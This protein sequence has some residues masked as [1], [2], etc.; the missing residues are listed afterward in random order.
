MWIH[1]LL[2]S[3]QSGRS[4][5]RRQPA[6]SGRK[7]RRSTAT[8]LALEQLED[9]CLPSSYTA[10]NAAQLAADITAANAAGG[11][12]TITLTAP[13]SSPYGLTAGLSIAANDDLT[14]VGNNDTIE[15]PVP[16]G[17]HGIGIAVGASLTLENL[18]LQNF[19][20]RELGQGVAIYNQ[21]VLTLSAVTVRSN[22]VL[23]S[24]TSGVARGGAIWSNGSLTLENGTLF[25]DNEAYGSSNEY[26]PGSNAY[27]GALYIA[28]GTA[29]IN[30]TSF[31]GNVALGGDGSGLPDGT[32]FGGAIYVA[33]GQVVMS[34]TT[35]NGNSVNSIG[36]NRADVCYGG[37][38]YV[39]GGTVTL[40]NCTVDSNRAA[41]AP[42]SYGGGLCIAGGTVTLTNDTVESN[43]A[44]YGG[45][46]YV[47]A[48][49]LTLTNCTVQSNT[50]TT[51]GGG[52]DI[53]SAA[54]VSIDPF[55]VANTVNNADSSGTNGSTANI[56]GTYILPPAAGQ[57]PIVV[58]AA[59]AN[60]SPVTGTTTNLSVL[61]ADAAGF[62]S[63]TY[64]WAV[65]SAPQA[66]PRPPSAATA[67]T[68]PRTPRPP[69]TRPALTPSRSRSPTRR[70]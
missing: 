63:L 37:G 22:G 4:R 70:A 58:H 9:R 38:L 2:A 32:A 44:T 21:G 24:P 26:G 10:T 69:S 15:G 3:W 51:Y 14:I 7:P 40:A 66:P 34:N 25:E 65:T 61:G 46:L 43:T 6:F 12:N 31:T 41:D 54:T 57:P 39:A 45:G 30:D 36:D 35:I 11:A 50:A 67:A 59:S 52:I 48:G 8:R 27:G 17:E 23:L 5:G 47:A 62:S 33:D 64:T 20:S 16:N 68:P 42:T 29:N 53:A 1:S 13:T 28:G 60:P 56:D 19:E 49:T 18:T 55:T